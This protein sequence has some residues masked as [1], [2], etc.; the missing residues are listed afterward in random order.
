M[1][2]GQGSL[3]RI[4]GENHKPPVAAAG[5]IV[6]P[7]GRA[8]GRSLD[9]SLQQTVVVAHEAVGDAGRGHDRQASGW[10]VDGSH[11]PGVV[12]LHMERVVVEGRDTIAVLR[13]RSELEATFGSRFDHRTVLLPPDHDHVVRH[14][15]CHCAG[16]MGR[17]GDH[18]HSGWQTAVAVEGRS[19][20]TTL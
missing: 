14:H 12:K 1:V 20:R 13:N 4:V 8:E 18:S 2:T 19:H 3:D 17:L 9:G 7:V 6:R 16:D 5:G 15:G 10:A 11:G